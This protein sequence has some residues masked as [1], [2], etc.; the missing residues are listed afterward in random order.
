[1]LLNGTFPELSSLSVWCCY[2]VCVF[3]L[4]LLLPVCVAV[5]CCRCCWGLWGMWVLRGLTSSVL[6]GD[7]DLHKFEIA[8]LGS[9]CPEEAEEAKTLI[10]RYNPITQ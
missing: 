2:H 4:L 6:R 10:P 9:L 7:A 1:M 8:Q 3:L 5:C